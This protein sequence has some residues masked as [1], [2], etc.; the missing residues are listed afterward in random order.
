MRSSRLAEQQQHIRLMETGAAPDMILAGHKST[1]REQWSSSW[2]IR[3]DI[4]RL[5]MRIFRQ[6]P[7]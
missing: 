5:V 2:L 3:F 7:F 6:F 1:L 4:S